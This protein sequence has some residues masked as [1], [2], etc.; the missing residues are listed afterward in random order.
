MYKKRE[1]K[2]QHL[3][4]DKIPYQ[5]VRLVG[6]QDNQPSVMDK[7][8]AIRLASNN[9]MDLILVSEKQE[10]PIVKIDEYSHF[11]YNLKKMEKDKKKNAQKV[12]QKEI[13]LS[14]NIA[15]NDLN[16][17]AKKAMSFLDDGD[18]VKCSLMLKGR[19]KSSPERGEYIMLKFA[20]IVKEHGVPDRMPKLENNKWFM[21]IRK[22]KR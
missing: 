16:T 2:Q 15:D 9:G 4:N 5:K 19:E 21:V 17:K 6:F 14:V 10:V 20:D 8:D 1:E 18:I 12:E 13:Q 22:K 7:Y 11:L 3:L